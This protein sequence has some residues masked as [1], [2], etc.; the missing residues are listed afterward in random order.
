MED[1]YIAPE[2]MQEVDKNTVSC[3]DTRNT[4]WCLQARHSTDGR[5]SIVGG[6]VIRSQSKDVHVVSA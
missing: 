2:K 6:H 1:N 3:N 5:I 4:L